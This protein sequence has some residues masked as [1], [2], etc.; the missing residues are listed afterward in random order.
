MGPEL[1]CAK[2]SYARDTYV[3]ESPPVNTTAVVSLASFPILAAARS[4]PLFDV[5]RLH[6]AVTWF[7]ARILVAVTRRR[8]PS[9]VGPG[10]SSKH[11]PQRRHSIVP[12]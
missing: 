1:G 4:L 2:P 10:L 6:S 12:E 8:S 3:G 5:Q 7:S 11:I 9:L